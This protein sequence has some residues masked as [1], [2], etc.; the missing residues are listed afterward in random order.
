MRKHVA[1]PIVVVGA[2]MGGL[3]AAVELARSGEEVLLVEA[4]SEVGGKARAVEVAG[5]RI[6]VGPTVLTMRWVF[7]ELFRR[8]IETTL[9]LAP[10][11]LTTTRS[12]AMRA[13]RTTAS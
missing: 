3:A 12:S 7:D 9:R 11:F 10:S 13:C 1:P 6:D 4:R 2:G 8:S 5:H